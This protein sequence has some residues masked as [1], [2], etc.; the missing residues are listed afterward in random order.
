MNWIWV[1][2]GNDSD[3]AA[4][5]R[6]GINGEFYPVNDPVDDV[7][8]R[9][10]QSRLRGHAGGLY[11]A[12]NWIATPTDGAAFAEWTHDLVTQI[13]RKLPTKGSTYPKVQ[14]NNERH[15][16]DVILAMLKRWRE[17]RP[18]KDTS[19][20]MEGMQGGWMSPA[21]ASEV[22]GY[23]VRLA[24][25]AYNGDMDQVWDTLALARDLRVRGF[26]DQLISP[27]YD[28]AHLPRYWNGF[29]FTMGRLP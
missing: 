10:E 25:Q 4:I 5:S 26:P 28:A 7:V 12:W 27:V 21:F 15:E 29:A 6:A 3:W 1:D 19:W 13:E 8:R 17:L 24:P 11:A 14:L 18:R 16:P 22:I 23:K 2:A 9:L 20:T